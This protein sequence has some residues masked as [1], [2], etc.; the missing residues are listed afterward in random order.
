MKTYLETAH[1]NIAWFNARFRADELELRPPFQRKPVWSDAQKSYLID[2]ILRGLPVP[3]LYMQDVVDAEGKELYIVVDGQQRIRAVLEFLDG[4]FT[5]EPEDSPEWGEAAFDDLSEEDKKRFFSYKFVVRTLP[6]MDEEQLRGIFKRLNRNVVALNAQELRHA[7][8]WGPFIKLMEQEADEN[9]FW[10]ESGLFSANAV[11]RMLDVEF[12][13]ELVVAYLHG[14]QEKKKKLEDYYQIYEK[15]FDRR[16]EVQQLMYTVTGELSSILPDLRQTRWRK[17]SDFYSLFVEFALHHGT[18]P[19]SREARN[20]ARARLVE[21]GD[22]VDAFLRLDLDDPAVLKATPP[23][24]VKYGVAVERAASDVASRKSR[25]EVLA[26][27][28]RDVFAAPGG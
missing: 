1:R 2:T 12:I 9:P 11:R 5:L 15:Q 22:E 26:D 14:V 4:D 10:S 19:L 21:F 27:L 28:L 20:L 8:Y 3:E 24:V 13:S 7:T 17:R 25:Q 18:L 16:D 6:Q 23:R